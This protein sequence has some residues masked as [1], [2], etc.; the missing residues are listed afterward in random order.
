V[1]RILRARVEQRFQPSRRT[2]EEKRLN[3]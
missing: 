2:F 1:R 3:R